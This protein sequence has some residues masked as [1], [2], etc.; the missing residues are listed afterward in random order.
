MLQP[1]I[2]MH[3][4]GFNGGGGRPAQMGSPVALIS[5][6]LCVLYY[7]TAVKTVVIV[8]QT[9]LQEEAILTISYM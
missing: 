5:A 7:Y 6:L 1:C 8:S 4:T 9:I 3:T 2:E